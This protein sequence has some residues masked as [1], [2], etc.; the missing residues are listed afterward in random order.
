MQIQD[1]SHEAFQVSGYNFTIQKEKMI[2]QIQEIW[3]KFRTSDLLS[4]IENVEFSSLHA[5]YH[6]YTED[7]FDMM[8]GFLTK[9]NSIQT[10]AEITTLQIPEQKYKFVEFDFVGPISVSETWQFI[11]SK[12]KEEVDRN[13]KFDLEMY[14]QDMKKCWI[15]V[16]VL[17]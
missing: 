17:E 12:S 8:I 10:N 1:Y 4:K 5:I 6:A 15:A 7:S 16:S 13:Y 11:N 9:G 3:D 2:S 14:S